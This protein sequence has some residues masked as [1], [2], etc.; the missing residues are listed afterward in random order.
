MDIQ[1]WYTI[2]LIILYYIIYIITRI[3]YIYTIYIYISTTTNLNTNYT[4]VYY[5][6]YF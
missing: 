4:G 2:I 6:A 3:L 5:V 1:V